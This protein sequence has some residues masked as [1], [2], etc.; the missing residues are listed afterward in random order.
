MQKSGLVIFV[1]D[2]A[3]SKTKL[4]EKRIILPSNPAR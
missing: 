3:V 1:I 4:L 2:K